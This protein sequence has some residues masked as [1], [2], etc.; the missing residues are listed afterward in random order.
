MIR[1]F[2]LLLFALN[3]VAQNGFVS[4]KVCSKCHPLIYKEYMGSMHR[5]SSIYND[6]VHRAVWKKHPMLKKKK[7]EC[8]VC[9]TPS[10]TRLIQRLDAGKPALPTPDE[11][12]KN[13]PIGCAYCHRIASVENHAKHGKNILSDKPKYYFAAKNGKSVKEAIEFHQKSSFFG[14][15]RATTGSPFHTIDYGNEIFA[16]GRVCLGC[17]D[18]KRN[19][20]GLNVCSMKRSDKASKKNCIGCHMPQVPGS[21]NTIQKSATH[22]YHG[23]AGLHNGSDY[24]KKYVKL[25]A[26]K[27]EGKLVVKIVNEANHQL[28]THPLRLAQLRISVER[29]G[30]TVQ[31]EPVNFFRIIGHDGKP[32]MP[33]VA[34]QVVKANTIDAASTKTVITDIRLQPQDQVTVTLGYYIVNPKAAKKLGITDKKLTTFQ[35]L[36]SKNFQF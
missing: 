9:H 1:V 35:V 27:N 36:V 25:E 8:A 23:F 2:I 19:G 15:S 28:F 26:V 6:P 4:S 12:Q 17:H 34:D 31:A 10:D 14:L 30:R 13:E 3:L 21:F 16:D 33:W 22:A 32:A 29:N 5:K 24:L 20:K 7:Y 18:H 11:I